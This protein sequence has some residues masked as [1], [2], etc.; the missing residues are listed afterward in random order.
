MCALAGPFKIYDVMPSWCGYLKAAAPPV[1]FLFAFPCLPS[2]HSR[3]ESSAFHIV[4][5]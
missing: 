5:E 2:T 4:K 3:S 1:I